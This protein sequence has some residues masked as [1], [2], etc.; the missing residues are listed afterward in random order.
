MTLASAGERAGDARAGG[1]SASGLAA[2]LRAVGLGT[3]DIVFVHACLDALG[4]MAG[5]DTAGARAD[6][7]LGALRNVVGGEGTIV[8]PTYTFSFCRQEPFDVARTPAVPGPWNT[9][10][11]LAERVR[12]LPGAL[13]SRD[14]IHSVAAFGPAAGGLVHTIASTCF[15]VGSVFDRLRAQGAR[16][17]LIGAPLDEATIRHH[18][19]EMVGVPFRYRKLFT[20]EIRDEAG[21]RREGW[22]YYVRLNA[23]NGFPDGKA[24][25]RRARELALCRAAQLGQ[26][27]VIA[28]DA[29]PFHELVVAELRRDPWGTARGPAGDPEALDDVAAGVAAVDAALAP[30]ATMTQMIEALWRLPRDIVSTGYDAALRALAT[31]VPMTVH[32]YPSG[33]E[34]WSWIVPEKWT[35]R[36][37]WLETLDGR[38]I[39]SYADH[40]LHVVSYSLP[41]EGV[42]SREELLDHLHVH[43]RLRTA[44]PFVFKYYERDWGLCCSEELRD[45]LR[46]DRY[47][48]VIRTMSTF[49]RLKVGE[50]VARGA[51]DQTIML[52][53]HLSHPA[54]VNDDLSGVAVGM[55]V[56]R[57]LQARTDLRYTYRFTI[58]PETIGSVAYLSQHEALIPKLKGGLFLEMLGRDTP[59]ALQLS[60]HGH[61]EVDR[62]FAAGLKAGDPAGRMGRYRSV[63]G[64]DERQYN[65]PG[66]R[67]PMLSLSRV[68]PA[69]DPAH[70]YLEYH[71]SYDT[72]DRVP[73]GALEASRDLVLGMI[74]VL[75]ANVVPGNRFSGEPF[76]SRFGVHVD[77]Y[78]NPEGNR[79]LFELL[80]RIDGTRSIID[81]AEECDIAF[82]AARGAVEELARRGVVRV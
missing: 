2:A 74:E 4:P 8:V 75:E 52:C 38:R 71:S 1:W 18:S 29:Q 78:E 40:P 35:C 69:T 21:M 73:P 54:M 45:S 47:R 37:A 30:G 58:V 12:G 27:E 24:L 36:E 64:N 22:V 10:V 76:C 5:V 16:I 79:A 50:V 49:G 14:P 20:G 19:E 25:E 48:V 57:I 70:P 28:V 77:A 82:A 9:S 66:V 53:A 17:C 60:H 62:C 31:Q 59:H 7:T 6:A 80:D 65:A 13:R 15:G 33:L 11:E 3:G 34:C 56:M 67:V 42:V 68:L 44:V 23:S 26:G 32:E 51:S 81:L 63:I 55:E 72:P 61:T 46:D 41:F 43:P 39:F